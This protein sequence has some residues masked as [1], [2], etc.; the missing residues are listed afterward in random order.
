MS[1]AQAPD[2]QRIDPWGATDE[3]CCRRCGEG[4]R[5]DEPEILVLRAD[6]LEVGRFHRRGCGVAALDWS[7]PR[8]AGAPPDLLFIIKPVSRTTFPSFPV[9]I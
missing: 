5:L 8:S 9:P 6:S 1:R 4:I 7:R 2:H 3:M